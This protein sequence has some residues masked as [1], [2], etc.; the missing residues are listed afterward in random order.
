MTGEDVAV[1]GGDGDQGVVEQ[2][3][4]AGFGLAVE[5]TGDQPSGAQTRR[6]RGQSV[7][8][9]LLLALGQLL[10]AAIQSPAWAS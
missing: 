4:E 6:I 10:L 9:I 1:G 7:F 5:Q 3:R 2:T 8:Q